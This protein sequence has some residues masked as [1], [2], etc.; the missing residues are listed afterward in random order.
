MELGIGSQLAMKPQVL[1]SMLMNLLSLPVN[2]SGAGRPYW[3]NHRTK[4]TSWQTPEV[5]SRPLPSGWEVRV[6]AQSG[7]TYFVN[8][9][10]GSSHWE[11]PESAYQTAPPVPS[12]SGPA[13]S[14]PPVQGSFVSSVSSVLCGHADCL[15]RVSGSCLLRSPFAFKDVRFRHYLLT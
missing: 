2:L 1:S 13:P 4:Q 3:V 7:R 5:L 8:H 9:A 12:A 6:D 14:N 11:I 15:S 10:N